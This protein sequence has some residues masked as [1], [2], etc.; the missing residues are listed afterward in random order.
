MKQLL[1]LTLLSAASCQTFAQDTTYFNISWQ[2]TTADSAAYYRTK[3]ATSPGWQVADHFIN[4]KLQMTGAYADDSMHVSQ[5]Q[6]TWYEDGRIAHRCT[7]V[8]GKLEG[9]DTLYYPDGRKKVTGQN[10]AG[11]KQGEWLGYYPSGKLS[12]KAK[13]E[14]GKQISASFYQENGSPKKN[15]SIFLRESEYPGGASQFLR[16]LNKTLRYPDSAVV[17]EIQGTVMTQFIVTKEGK[18]S[19]LRII[20]SVNKYL[21]EEALRVMR[22]MSDWEPAIYG[23]ILTDTYRRQPIV[24]SLQN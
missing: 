10:Q 9:P 3:I 23:G 1:L 20:R 15:V 17:Y 19:D 8:Q 24:F 11:D 6:F 22:L 4:G 18:V 12:G 5:G 2:K 14:K 13:Y 16:F 21:D 7:C